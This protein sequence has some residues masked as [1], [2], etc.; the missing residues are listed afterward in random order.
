MRLFSSKHAHEDLGYVA[1]VDGHMHIKGKE[2]TLAIMDVKPY[3][4]SEKPDPIRMQEAA[5]MAA[6]IS[7]EPSFV[8]KGPK[9]FG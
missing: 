7:G 2:E 4:R 1:H 3:L 9:P 8:A 6:W 5:Q